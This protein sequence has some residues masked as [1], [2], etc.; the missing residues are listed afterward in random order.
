MIFPSATLKRWNPFSTFSK[1]AIK[2]RNCQYCSS[3]VLI[4][5]GLENK[6]DWE[7]ERRSKLTSSCF[8]SALGFFPERRVQLWMQ[9]VGLAEPFTGCTATSWSNA[10]KTLAL[11]CYETLT[12]NEVTLKGFTVHR[13]HEWLAASPDGIIDHGPCG[14]KKE[15]GMVHIKCPYFKGK[16]EGSIPWSTL[17]ACH[18][19]Q[20]QGL[21]EILDR[22]WID[23]YVWTPKGS[24]LFRV[25][26]DAHYWELIMPALSDF[27]FQHVQPAR[28][29]RATDER[30]DVSKLKPAARHKLFDVIRRKSEALV[31]DSRLLVREFYG[32]ED[33]ILKPLS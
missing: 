29:L 27:W 22:S 21:M 33:K 32:D 4:S 28:R 20:A 17:P 2:T 30:K 8:N 26:R 7:E 6:Y 31:Q 15:V 3:N 1:R 12:G 18:M 10:H 5:S 14:D 11:A 13:K 9:K 16:A 19:P 24:S 25:Q 23:F